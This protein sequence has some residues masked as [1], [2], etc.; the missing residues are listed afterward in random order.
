MTLN[1]SAVKDVPIQKPSLNLGALSTLGETT[2]APKAPS[3]ASKVGSAVMDFGKG[4]VKETISTL[5]P[6]GKMVLSGVNKLTGQNLPIGGVPE[7]MLQQNNTAQQIGGFAGDIAM[8][9]AQPELGLEKLG[10]GGVLKLAESGRLTPAIA[11]TLK[12]LVKSKYGIKAAELLNDFVV[13]AGTKTVGQVTSGEGI[14]IPEAVGTGVETALAGQ[15]I[16]PLT[17]KIGSMITGKGTSNIEKTLGHIKADVNTMTKTEQKMAEARLKSTTFSGK[18]FTPSKT[19]QR[20]AE[21]LDG[22]TTGNPINDKNVIKSEISTRGKEVE[23]YL[24]RAQ[25]KVSAKQQMEIF[26]NISNETK[27][28][29]TK[30]E[31]KVYDEQKKLFEGILNEESKGK[32]FTTE[33]FY[34]ALKKFE[35]NITEKLPRGQAAIM[36]PT[37]VASVKLHAASDIRAGVRDLIGSLNSE[38]KGKMFDLASLYDVKDTVITKATQLTG[39]SVSRAL[40]SPTAKTIG[41]VTGIGGLITGGYEAVKALSK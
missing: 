1:L 35:D 37:G 21:I 26:D 32:G 10:L 3:F 17:A 39:N 33:T 13:G 2:V 12:V 7:S 40:T 11:D 28:Y 29:L 8:I 34:K 27:K 36:D 20:A 31:V 38:F 19:E 23:D 14:N 15:V 30:S 4:A 9:A 16:R 25:T 41:A 6:I 5:Q 18:E 24:A 22:K